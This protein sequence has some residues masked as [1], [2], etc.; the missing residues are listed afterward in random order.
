[1]RLI[2]QNQE[3]TQTHTH[4]FTKEEK[5]GPKETFYWKI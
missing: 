3:N 1:M 5:V 2:V 4:T